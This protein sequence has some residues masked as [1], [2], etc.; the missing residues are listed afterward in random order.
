MSF[1][2]GVG[3]TMGNRGKNDGKEWEEWERLPTPVENLS[4]SR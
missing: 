3:G 2:Y 1:G 4:G